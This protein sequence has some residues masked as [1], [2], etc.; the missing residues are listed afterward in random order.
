MDY[1]NDAGRRGIKP[2]KVMVIHSHVVAHQVFAMRLINWLDNIL[3]Y[4]EGFRAL[5]SLILVEQEVGQNGRK[6]PSIL[7]GT[8]TFLLTNKGRTR[9]VQL[10]PIFPCCNRYVRSFLPGGIVYNLYVLFG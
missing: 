8:R 9:T 4:S 2:L 5:F 10:S 6:Q 1:P 7:E 3:G